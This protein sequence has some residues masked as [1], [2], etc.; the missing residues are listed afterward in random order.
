MA[1]PK[2]KCGNTWT[3]D[4]TE[5]N[6]EGTGRGIKRVQQQ[7]REGNRGFVKKQGNKG[8]NNE[9]TLYHNVRKW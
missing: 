6:T 1:R 9:N 8:I 2:H 4:L 5:E 3:V 7:T